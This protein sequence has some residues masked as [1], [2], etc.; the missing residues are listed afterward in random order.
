MISDAFLHLGTHFAY[1]NYLSEVRATQQD[2]N[3]S[4]VSLD[5]H[6]HK[7]SR[8]IF[9]RLASKRIQDRSIISSIKPKFDDQLFVDLCVLYQMRMPNWV[10]FD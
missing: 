6:V 7:I 1:L 5:F 2:Q 9:S 3:D 8:Y 4:T 10:G